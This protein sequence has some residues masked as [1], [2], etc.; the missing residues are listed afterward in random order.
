MLDESDYDD[1]SESSESSEDDR[2]LTHQTGYESL[3]TP[4]TGIEG[5]DSGGPVVP[6]MAPDT[7][8][9]GFQDPLPPDFYTSKGDE[10]K[11]DDEEEGVVEDDFDE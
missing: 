1:E 7:M 3:D 9:A 2:P 8:Y 6:D 11:E 5:L 10:D 4:L